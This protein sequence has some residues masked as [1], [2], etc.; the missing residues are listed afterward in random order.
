MAH[1]AAAAAGRVEVEALGEHLGD[2]GSEGENDEVARRRHAHT[3]AVGGD[4]ASRVEEEDA[5]DDGGAFAR[6]RREEGEGTPHPQPRLEAGTGPALCSGGGHSVEH[7]PPEAGE[8]GR[9]TLL[10]C[11]EP[12]VGVGKQPCLVEVTVHAQ[13]EAAEGLGWMLR[14][15]LAFHTAG[16]PRARRG[17][18]PRPTPSPRA[19]QP[20][21]GPGVEGRLRR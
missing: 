13:R 10:I 16:L 21:R 14:V 3:A 5:L 1:A 8:E 18:G 6:A 19:C 17:G 9:E 4:G 11:P 20:A 2:V 15:S 12:G 7:E